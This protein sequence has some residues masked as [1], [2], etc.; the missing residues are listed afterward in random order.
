[1]S[2]DGEIT[3]RI[4]AAIADARRA[5]R[6]GS[7]GDAPDR[8][9]FIVGSP[10]GDDLHPTTAPVASPLSV[11]IVG[12]GWFAFDDRGKRL[13]GRLGDLRVDDRGFLVDAD[14]RA[15][16][17]F[18]P[19][20]N[21]DEA[22]GRMVVAAPGDRRAADGARI[23]A[24]GIVSVNG[25]DGPR[26]VGT[27]ALAVFRAPAMLARVGET[28]AAANRASG[29]PMLVRPGDANAGTLRAHAVEVGMVDLE[30]DLASA[31]R[32][33]R[34]SDLAS[35]TASADDRCIRT[36]MGIVQ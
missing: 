10:T 28:L 14:G 8:A 25:P 21:D 31:W 13:Y 16:L 32:L 36:A 30:G 5:S 29:P 7:I 22:I 2:I 3:A 26:V 9:G 23:G 19:G 27:I 12:A 15:V 35:A 33:G 20:S 24:D 1:V 11:A 17:G 34:Q 4:D 6:P 18:P